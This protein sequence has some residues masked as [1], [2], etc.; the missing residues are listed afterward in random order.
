VRWSSVRLPEL[1]TL[2]TCA[3]LL[4]SRVT[5]APTLVMVSVV[6]TAVAPGPPAPV[7]TL[8]SA[9]R[10]QLKV[11]TSPLVVAVVRSDV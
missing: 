2:N 1:P 8:M 6:E 11:I 5:L 4:P 7:V 10:D 3:A 9:G